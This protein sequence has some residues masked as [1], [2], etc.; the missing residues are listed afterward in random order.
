MIV[1]IVLLF[2]LVILNLGLLKFFAKKGG[3]LFLSVAS[4]LHYLYFLYS[5]FIFVAVYGFERFKLIIDHQLI[6]KK[7]ATVRSAG[8]VEP[9]YRNIPVNLK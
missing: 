1:P 4:G 9:V 7:T 5:S 6:G 8:P 3:V 2:F